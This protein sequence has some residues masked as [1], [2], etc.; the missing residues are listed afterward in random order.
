MSQR[1]PRSHL[2][3]SYSRSDRIAVDKLAADLRQRGYALWIDVDERGIEPGEDWRKELVK[4]MSGAEGVIACISPDFLASPFC[5]A[6]IEQAQSENKP[7]YPVFVRRLDAAHSLADF[8]LDHLQYSDLTTG[9]DE[10]LRRLLVALP[11][12]QAPLR[13]ALQVGR[14]TAAVVALLIVAFVVILLATQAGNVLTTPTATPIPPTPTVSLA[15]YKVGV[16]MSYFA[17]DPPGAMSQSDADQIVANFATSL[18]GQLS[19]ELTD[20]ELSFGM[21]GPQ[22]VTRVEGSSP[23]ARRQS[24][25]ARLLEHGAKVVIYGIIRYDDVQHRAV[26]EPEFYIDTGRYFNEASD[27]TGS[28]A[29]GRDVPINDTGSSESLDAKI[30]ALS[31]IMTGV[32][33]YMTQHYDDALA[34]YDKALAVPN[35]NTND[36]KE[37][38]YALQ[39]NAYMKLAQQAASTCDR[40]T[41]LADTES[42]EAA[43]NQSLILAGDIDSDKFESAAEAGLTRAYAGLAN[44]YAV[45]ALWLPEANDGCK[46]NQL[47]V[48]TLQQADSYVALYE[49]HFHPEDF[50][51]GVRRKLLL[52]ALQ[53]RFL[54]WAQQA[55]QSTDTL[56]D[57][58]NPAYV[59]FIQVVH[60]TIAGY[61]DRTDNTWAFPVMEAHIF[62]GQAHYARGELTDAVDDYGAALAI[63]DDPNNRDLLSPAR[64]M[65]T[66]GWRGDAYMRIG[67]FA[68]A[69]DDYDQALKLATSLDNASAEARY[70]QSRQSAVDRLIALQTSIAPAV[71]A[72]GTTTGDTT[73]TPEATAAP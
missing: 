34:A 69:S 27:I 51:G 4:Q 18:K 40:A 19:A 45:R 33:Q 54:L 70:Q 28:Y 57:P 36:G 12:P 26:L 23:D 67:N 13:R 10:G 58:T 50:N 5:K 61:A 48:G 63:Y 7:I 11:A 38:V 65:T 66:Y 41:T 21:D 60:E 53:V 42:A 52:T 9:Y 73:A 6:E 20:S 39:G 56:H 49:L 68:A 30:T 32:F 3:V 71:T 8:K 2:F 25:A 29:F 31:Y 15:D 55:V 14:V 24:A 43:Y 47:D 59:A 46:A 35:W 1:Q 16:L 22:G 64:A 37:I 72:T 62:S 17:V 44:T